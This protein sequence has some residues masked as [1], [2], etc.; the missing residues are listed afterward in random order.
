MWSGFQYVDSKACCWLNFNLWAAGDIRL[1]VV[2][3]SIQVVILIITAT[4]ITLIVVLSVIIVLHKIVHIQWVSKKY[5]PSWLTITLA[6]VDEFLKFSH[7]LICRKILYVY[8][9]KI[10]NTP[11]ICGYTT[12]WKFKIQKCCWFWQHPQQTVDMFLRTLW[13]A[14]I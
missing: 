10:S 8:T 1:L 13:G 2:T 11:A 5:T 7:Q 4:F 12:L 14:K 3:I 9:T 6:N